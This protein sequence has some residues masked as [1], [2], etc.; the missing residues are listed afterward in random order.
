MANTPEQE[1]EDALM[2]LSGAEKNYRAD[3]SYSNHLAV[4]E[5]CQA[6]RD[7]F[8]GYLPKAKVEAAIG[9]D[10]EIKSHLG[11]AGGVRNIFRADIREKL[12]LKK[13]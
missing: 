7:L 13:G 11:N 2:Y 9:E 12:G 3:P 10:E 1:L 6:I 4:G 8:A 5:R